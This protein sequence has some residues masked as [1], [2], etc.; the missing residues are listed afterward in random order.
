M[1]KSI[2]LLSII[3]FLV[4]CQSAKHVETDRHPQTTPITEFVTEPIVKSGKEVSLAF[5]GDVIIHERVRT[6]EEKT[7]EGYQTI[8]ENIQSY[9]D[10]ADITYA[11]LEGPVAP[12]YGGVTGFPMF[13]FP[14]KILPA[15]QEH[16]FDVVSTANNH[17]LDRQSKGIIKTIENL[18][19]Y[20]LLHTGTVASEANVTQDKETWWALTPIEGTTKSI[21]WLACTEMTNGNRDKENQVLYC[22]KHKEKIKTLIQKLKAMPD[23]AAIVLT[24]HW[25]EED[26]FE[27]EPHVKAWGKTMLEEGAS[28][29]VGSHPHVVRK[30]QEYT[31]SDQRRTIVAYS[32]GNFVSNQPWTK[33]KLSM[34]LYLKFKDNQDQKPYELIEVKYIPLWTTRTIQKDGTSKYRIDAV[35][36]EKKIPSEAAQILKSE[37]GNDKRIKDQK[38]FEQMLNIKKSDLK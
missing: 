27:I 29:I 14:E 9:L 2:K 1:L 4:S 31:T 22:F 33:N 38:Q 13:N 25:G 20:K 5:V 24:P 11:N 12:E 34:L 35:W 6:R 37:L 21:A 10:Q 16:G 23:V 17:A 7:N 8:W 32:L 19:K 15:L 36:D 30:I 28:A 18:S 26:A 3:G